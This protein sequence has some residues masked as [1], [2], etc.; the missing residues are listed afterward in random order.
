MKPSHAPASAPPNGF[1]QLPSGEDAGMAGAMGSD[2][3]LRVTARRQTVADLAEFLRS[4]D[5]P[6]VDASG[7]TAAYDFTLEFAPEN[8]RRVDG[9]PMASQESQGDSHGPVVYSALQDQLGLRLG[10]EEGAVR[11]PGDRPYRPGAKRQ[12]MMTLAPRRCGSRTALPAPA[13]G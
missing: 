11:R 9:T 12:L 3:V 2:L 7:L 6:V 5:R 4:L 1:A 13:G 10:S 8:L